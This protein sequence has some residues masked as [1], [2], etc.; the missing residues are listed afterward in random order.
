MYFT[1]IVAYLHCNKNQVTNR[2][3]YH[4]YCIA[5]H[6]AYKD[7]YEDS[8]TVLAGNQVIQCISS[9]RPLGLMVAA[10]NATGIPRRE[11]EEEDGALSGII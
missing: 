10:Y 9:Y 5:V 7:S 8:H 11:Y 6:N 3:I 1:T 4:Q 2:I